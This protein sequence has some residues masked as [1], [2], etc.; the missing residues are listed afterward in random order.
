MSFARKNKWCVS[1]YNFF[2]YYIEV[3]YSEDMSDV[4]AVLSFYK[5]IENL[6]YKYRIYMIK[7][8]EG[9][10]I[11]SDN[12]RYTDLLEEWLEE[13]QILFPFGRG[14]SVG[15]SGNPDF[16]PTQTIFTEIS[17]YGE[18]GELCTES[19]NN[20][21]M[22]LSETLNEGLEDW[23]IDNRVFDLE[24]R[25][26]DVSPISIRAFQAIKAG[27]EGKNERDTIGISISSKTDI[28]LPWILNIS[29]RETD[30]FTPSYRIDDNRELTA[31]HT[32]RLN[33]FLK[34]VGEIVESLNGTIE[35][36]CNTHF[37]REQFD[38][39]GI[40]LDANPP[41]ID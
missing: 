18:E 23:E 8:F 36:E 11:A 7:E 6:C 9:E 4:S 32:L 27:V 38:R 28:W 16:M 17:F 35:L 34:E 30:D 24:D 33:Q 22:I 37:Y 31:I 39:N 1:D 2:C 12:Y 40:I 10:F 29:R 15:E 14:D 13:T 3:P 25:L 20:I 19:I 26:F 21:R 41:L 5:N